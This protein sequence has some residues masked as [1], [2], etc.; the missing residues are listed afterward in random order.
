MVDRVSVVMMRKVE[1][2]G[3]MSDYLD[4]EYRII[5]LCMQIQIIVGII[6]YIC[7]S[8]VLKYIKG[9]ASQIYLV[10]GPE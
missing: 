1:R 7:S 8:S 9:L 3:M 5:I 10:W 4:E 2:R 6:L